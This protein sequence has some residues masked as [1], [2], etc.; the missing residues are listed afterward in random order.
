MRRAHPY[1]LHPTG[2]EVPGTKSSGC[3]VF[4]CL[5]LFVANE[6]PFSGSGEFGRFP[7]GLFQPRTVVIDGNG[8]LREVAVR[9]DCQRSVA[10]REG[11]FPAKGGLEEGVAH[12]R[13]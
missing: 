5:L 1:R 8:I 4:L 2:E 3:L 7:T 12:G 11:I 10:G 9:Q 13:R 6:L